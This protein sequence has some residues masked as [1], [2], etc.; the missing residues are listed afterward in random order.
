MTDATRSFA[1]L[2]AMNA[3][4]GVACAILT[5]HGIG[6]EADRVRADVE[7]QK[8]RRKMQRR[9]LDVGHD[10]AEQGAE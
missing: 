4:L 3:Q 6:H 5:A 7:E 1:T 10:P 2:R 9:D 8:L